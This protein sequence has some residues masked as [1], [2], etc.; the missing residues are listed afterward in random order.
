MRLFRNSTLVI[1]AAIVTAC[2]TAPAP[3]PVSTAYLSSL[4]AQSQSYDEHLSI[5][6]DKFRNK[7]N[8]TKFLQYY[9]WDEMV[10]ISKELNST[11]R[12][13]YTLSG[14]KKQRNAYIEHI[15]SN[16]GKAATSEWFRLEGSKLVADAVAM[17]DET[18]AFYSNA[19]KQTTFTTKFFQEVEQLSIKQGEMRGMISELT[20][21]YD[22][23]TA[24]Y[25]E[26]AKE[27]SEMPESVQPVDLQQAS[28]MEGLRSWLNNND[29]TRDLVRG[30]EKPRNC[31]VYGN[32][33]SC[34]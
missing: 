25:T 4:I 34:Q 9:S 7:L 20:T 1:A 24:Y 21:L 15:R 32:Q 26:R 11:L 27:A 31:V 5:L 10:G 22:E 23:S 33:M 17:Q 16:P 29:Y 18:S 30:L 19:W 14:Q 2:A 28:L 13:I 8:T 6:D 12:E 3:E